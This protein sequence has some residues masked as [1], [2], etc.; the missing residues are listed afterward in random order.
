MYAMFLIEAVERCGGA[1]LPEET[2]DLVASGSFDNEPKQSPRA[3]QYRRQFLKVVIEH[4]LMETWTATKWLA[5][6]PLTD[7]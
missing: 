4:C 2:L 1:N 3:L 5:R 6:F 7:L